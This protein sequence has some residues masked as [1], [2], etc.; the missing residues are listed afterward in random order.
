[1]LGAP[2][3]LGAALMLV[4]IIFALSVDA[5]AVRGR[6][7][8]VPLLADD[9][10]AVPPPAFNLPVPHGVKIPSPISCHYCMPLQCL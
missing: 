10:E 9:C 8:L 4:A 7:L 3:L 5:N 6:P 1:M 2:Y